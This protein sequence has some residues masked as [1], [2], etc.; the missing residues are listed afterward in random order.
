[1]KYFVKDYFQLIS[2]SIIKCVLLYNYHN[3]LAWI[4]EYTYIVIKKYNIL[5]KMYSI[6]T[7]VF[8]TICYNLSCNLNDSFLFKNYVLTLVNVNYSSNDLSINY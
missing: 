3:R 4:N 2:V 7:P 8:N 6:S 1:M 5:L